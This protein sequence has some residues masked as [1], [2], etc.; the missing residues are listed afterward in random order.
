MTIEEGN[1]TIADFHGRYGY[2][3]PLY[4][5]S[6]WE[7]LHGAWEKFRDMKLSLEDEGFGDQWSR[8]CKAVSTALYA[9]PIS[10]VFERLVRAIQWYNQNKVNELKLST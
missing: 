8:H 10:V 7:W 3:F 9:Y 4:Y 2:P 6:S 1:K 5:H